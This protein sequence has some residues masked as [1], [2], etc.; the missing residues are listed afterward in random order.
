[1]AQVRMISI[2]SIVV[3][4]LLIW[5]CGEADAVQEGA[6]APDVNLDSSMAK[7]KLGWEEAIRRGVEQHP[8]VQI[9]EH[10]MLASKAVTGQVESANY[11]QV[12]GVYAS[13]GGNTRV[14]ANLNISG[15]L[16]KPVT[17]LTTPGARVDYLITDFGHTAHRILAS[18]EL[19][20][21]AEQQILTAKALVVLG[22][23]QTYL[24]CLK[25]RRLVELAKAMV[26]TRRK[27]QDQADLLYRHELRSKLDQEFASVD[28]DRA[29]LTLLKARNGLKVCFSDLNNAMG[30]HSAKEYDLEDLPVDI[31]SDQ[32]IEPLIKDA[33]G[34]RPELLGS[35][36]QVRAA[37][38]AVKAAEALKYGHVDALGTLAYTWWGS[39]EYETSGAVKNPGKQLGWYGA[40]VA[41]SFP[42]FTGGRIESQAEEAEARKGQ[43]A[44]DTRSIANDVVLQVFQAYISRLMAK[45]QIEVAKKRVATAQEAL[46]LAQARYKQRLGPI[47]EVMIATTDLLSAEV[48]LAQARYEYRTSQVALAY[49]TGSGY[50]GY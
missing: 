37:E 18:K 38:E 44:A 3:S 20:K 39:K 42:L 9:A 45:E 11:P 16:P 49:A 26:E 1:M 10:E 7:E 33:L 34:K 6:K 25:Q 46:D 30:I 4:V 47:L 13:T 21:S 24:E 27:I 29:E 35:E 28:T 12:T 15:S 17:Y 31:K 23:Q 40:A 19:T 43:A 41:S 22:V 14:L 8:R 48:G 5:A 2:L 36:A 50:A 32:P